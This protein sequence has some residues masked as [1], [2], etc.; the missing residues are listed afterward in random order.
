MIFKQN[1]P[2]LDI[3]FE[4]RPDFNKKNPIEK[5]IFFYRFCQIMMV[6]NKHL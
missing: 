2:E 1:S 6:I 5:Y 3:S 4:Y